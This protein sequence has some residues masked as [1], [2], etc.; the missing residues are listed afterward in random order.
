MKLTPAQEKAI[1]YYE[2]DV[3]GNDPFWGDPK[4]YVTL[5]SLFF[6][7]IETERCRAAEGKHLNPAVYEDPER[8]YTLCRDILDAFSAS[9][10]SKPR[11]TWRV[12]R[13]AD[14][15]QTKKAGK[16]LSFTST[17]SGGFLKAYGD[18]IGIALMEFHI[19]AGIPCFTYKEVLQDNYLKEDE[20]E[21]LLPPGLLLKI[22]EKP[23]SREE[24]EITDAEGKEPV[25]SCIAEITGIAQ[26]T[27]DTPPVTD[28]NEAMIRVYTALNAGKEPDSEDVKKA[29]QWKEYFCSRLLANKAL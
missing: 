7:G 2:G 23:L 25:V 10:L 15:L 29:M 24:R 16:T 9:D 4:A 8:L 14:Y 18:R 11:I 28:G 1:R 27:K 13:Y 6:D 17:S 3:Q 19:P 26:Y 21:I 20:Q 12:E 22:T 5:N